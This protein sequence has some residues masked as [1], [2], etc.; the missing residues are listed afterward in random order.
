MESAYT[1][2]EQSNL[3]GENN[4]YSIIQQYVWSP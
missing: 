1:I 2:N 3:F 4:A